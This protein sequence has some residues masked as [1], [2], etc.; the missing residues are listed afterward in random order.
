MQS[1]PAKLDC[2]C[3]ELVKNHKDNEVNKIFNGF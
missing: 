1:D 3:T 2:R